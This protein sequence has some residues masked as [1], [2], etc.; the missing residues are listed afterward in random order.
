MSKTIA[1][2]LLDSNTELMLFW[3]LV[4]SIKLR[5]RMDV[6]KVAVMFEVSAIMSIMKRNGCY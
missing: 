6:I 5:S 4:K 2:F 1:T 3:K